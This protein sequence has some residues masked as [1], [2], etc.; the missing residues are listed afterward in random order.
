VTWPA[1]RTF[2]EA[3]ALGPGG[4]DR[5]PADVQD[6]FVA[7]APTWLDE[8]RDPEALAIDP[9]RVRTFSGPALLTLGDQSPPFFPLIVDRIAQ[10]LAVG[11][12]DVC[13]R[14]PRAAADPLGRYD[15]RREGLC[16]CRCDVAE[17]IAPRTRQPR[18]HARA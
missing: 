8:T 7:N 13:R 5:L 17:L 12:E 4:W 2:A 18:V 9:D 6:T 11:H 10:V 14:R 1:A 16:A 15:G 3:V